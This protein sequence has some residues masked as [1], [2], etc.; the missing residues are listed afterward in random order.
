MVYPN[1]VQKRGAVGNLLK[2]G[3][4]SD[5]QAKQLGIDDVDIDDLGG[6][7]QMCPAENPNYQKADDDQMVIK[8]SQ[9]D[10]V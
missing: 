2:I 10:S 3:G 6:Q 4:I 8:L 1:P 5:D 9:C 7:G